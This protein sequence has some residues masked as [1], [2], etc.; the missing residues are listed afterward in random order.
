ME[1]I[2]NRSKEAENLSLEDFSLREED[3]T[4]LKN[5]EFGY[6]TCKDNL[7]LV[8]TSVVIR[9]MFG[10]TRHKQIRTKFPYR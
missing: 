8:Y 10:P 1:K 6:H 3:F 9:Q 7:V 4:P 5:T 2:P